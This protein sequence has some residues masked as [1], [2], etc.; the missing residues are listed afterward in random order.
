MWEA[1]GERPRKMLPP[2]KTIAI[3]TFSLCISLIS[4]ANSLITEELRF[5]LFLGSA[6]DSPESFNIIRL[7]LAFS[8]NFLPQ[9]PAV[10]TPLFSPPELGLSAIL[11]P[12]SFPLGLLQNFGP[13]G[14]HPLDVSGF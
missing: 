3:S 4:F 6:S 5:S 7:Y 1:F 9:L 11:L 13:Q 14:K 10:Q 8:F 2:P 12:T